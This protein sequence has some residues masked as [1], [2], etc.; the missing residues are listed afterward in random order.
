MSRTPTI[1]SMPLF[2]LNN[3]NY[4]QVFLGFAQGRGINHEGTKDTK[5]SQKE[6]GVA[7]RVFS[8]LPA[9]G[10][11]SPGVHA[12]VRRTKPHA[13]RPVHGSFGALA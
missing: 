3:E 11:I 9:V 13:S 6:A 12:G 7:G 5:D 10:G 8:I 1:Y 4:A 2:S